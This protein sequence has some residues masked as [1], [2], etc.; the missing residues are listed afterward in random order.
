MGEGRIARS[1]ASD[2]R[3]AVAQLV[4]HVHGKHEVTGSKPV[5]SSII[6]LNDT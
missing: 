2:F 3:A 6:G 1:Q 4:E 5:C